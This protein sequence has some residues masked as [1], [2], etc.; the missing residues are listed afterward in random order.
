MKRE[1]LIHPEFGGNKWRKLKYNLI[2]ARSLN[3]KTLL[4]FGG[5]F[6]NHIYATAGAGKYFGF[7]TIGII[8]GEPHTPLN[9]TLSFAQ[10]RGMR[11]I[12]VN[13]KTYKD[14]NNKDFI[15]SLQQ[16]HGDFYLIPEGG[17]NA[18]ALLGCMETIEEINY[19]INK[20][21][22]FDNNET[23]DIISCACGTGATLAGL[24]RSLKP[25][26]RA[27]GFSALKGGSFLNDE[28]NRFLLAANCTHDNWSIETD[29]HFGG[30]AKTNDTLFQFMHD[31][32][33]EYSIPLDCVYT[34]KMFYG[35]FDLIRNRR[36]K[37]GTR[38]V[39]IHT[40]GLQGNAGFKDKRLQPSS[41]TSQ[42]S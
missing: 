8:R 18:L 38:I 29:Y 40:G 2:D 11:L 36:F 37:K 19:E 34:A 31:F 23:F 28:V 4:T 9:P 41:S 27:I 20:P 5:A 1:D 39:A 7:D 10:S 6:S 26:Q 15:N 32:E 22:S 17:S 12:Y 24:I 13:R 30:Y 3:K 35:L 33:A 42:R 25:E 14:K 16:E 21:D